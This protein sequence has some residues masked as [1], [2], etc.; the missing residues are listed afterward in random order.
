[1][2]A[3]GSFSSINWSEIWEQCEENRRRR[4]AGGSGK[5]SETGAP[6]IS[7]PEDFLSSYH[8][9]TPK[10]LQP[11]ESQKQQEGVQKEEV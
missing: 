3:N 11:M 4:G 2:A 7:E 5:R 6:D 9:L 10:K 8:L 1:M